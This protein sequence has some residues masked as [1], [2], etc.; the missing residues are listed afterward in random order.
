MCSLKLT[1]KTSKKSNEIHHITIQAIF[2]C[3]QLNKILSSTILR[4][5]FDRP[6]PSS[7]DI[8]DRTLPTSVANNSD[9][10]LIAIPTS[11]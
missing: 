4:Y 6:T 5:Q 2:G 3:S 1:R 7:L 10:W 8:C 9:L 11:P